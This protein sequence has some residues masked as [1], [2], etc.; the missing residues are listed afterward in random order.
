MFR[1]ASDTPPESQTHEHQNNQFQGAEP[2]RKVAAPPPHLTFR[3]MAP[4]PSPSPISQWV[5]DLMRFPFSGYIE[6][7]F[8]A[9]SLDIGLIRLRRKSFR[10]QQAINERLR[11]C[12]SD[13]L[14]MHATLAYCLAWKRYFVSRKDTK[15]ALNFYVLETIK[16]MR[17]RLS[18]GSSASADAF[19]VYVGTPT[20]SFV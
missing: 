11:H 18:L 17:A 13:E 2:K 1:P 15:Q 3:T 20:L 4:T 12:V 14:H 8:R 7:V 6:T 16:R 19:L 9:E 5:S 10:H